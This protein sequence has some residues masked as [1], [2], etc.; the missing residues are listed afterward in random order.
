MVVLELS[1]LVG[2]VCCV[3]FSGFFLG[4]FCLYF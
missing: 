1:M 4:A 2:R 3:V